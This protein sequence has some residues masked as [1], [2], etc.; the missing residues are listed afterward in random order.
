MKYTVYYSGDEAH[1]ESIEANTA[2]M[3]AWRFVQQQPRT[4]SSQL[5]VESHP[6]VPW[7]V[8]EITHYRACD[9]ASK[10]APVDE[11][12]PDLAVRLAG[13]REPCYIVSGSVESLRLLGTQLLHALDAPSPNS[14]LKRIYALTV[15]PGSGSRLDHCLSFEVDPDVRQYWARRSGFRGFWAEYGRCLA[16]LFLLSL[17]CIGLWTVG[18]WIF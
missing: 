15:V 6:S 9:L 1:P 14:A 16:L 5:T 17:A 3:A 2:E 13:G 7:R 11:P 10:P 12:E 18:T 4:D 8:S